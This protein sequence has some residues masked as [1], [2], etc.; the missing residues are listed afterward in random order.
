MKNFKVLEDFII[1]LG[2]MAILVI[3]LFILKPVIGFFGLI[4]LLVSGY[5]LY[6]KSVELSKKQV[7]IIEN[8]NRNFESASSDMVFNMPFP[9]V[10]LNEDSEVLWYNQPF[11]KIVN[12]DSLVNKNIDKIIDDIDVK[13]VDDDRESTRTIDLD[14]TYYRVYKNNV[15]KNN[16]DTISILYFVDDTDYIDV[17]NICNDMRICFGSV[18]IDNYDEIGAGKKGYHKSVITSEV[19]NIIL[20]YFTQMGG[21]VRKYDDEKYLVIANSVSLISMIEDK[22]SLLDRVRDIGTENESTISLSIGMSDAIDDITL[23][24]EQSREAV[25]LALG[26]GGDQVALRVK[27]GYEF[28]GGKTQAK[29]KRNR[30]RARVIGNSLSN[31]ID[32]SNRIFIMGHKNADLD[33]IGADIG[34]LGVVMRKNKEGYIVLNSSNPGIKV[35]L[36]EMEKTAG[37]FYDKIIDSE[38]ALSLADKT[39]SLVISVD[40]HKTVISE[41]PRLLDIVDDVVI[42]DHHRKGEDAIKDP[43]LSYVEPYA[44]STCEL[45][46]EILEF[47]DDNLDLSEFEACAMLAG[48]VLDTKNFTSKTGVRTFEAASILRR[49]GADP[50]KVNHYFNNDIDTVRLTTKVI[51]NANILDDK[52]AISKLEEDVDSG[53]LIAAQAADSLLN[54]RGIDASFVLTDMGDY[55]HVSGRSNGNVSVQIILEKLGGG[56]HLTSAA[57]QIRDHSIDESYDMLVSAIRDYYED[58][59]I[60]EEEN[61]DY[62][63][64]GS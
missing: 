49:Q 5:F 45:I 64:Q 14:G 40:N 46:T 15:E 52:I 32:E 12:D 4:I 2:L 55:I 56:G 57:C 53:I 36:E 27:D 8:L 33:A 19:E 47:M 30:V 11:L 1:P 41:E 44:S 54:I 3:I 23:A 10:L 29:E 31:L 37:D 42:I 21:V 18:Y 25:D 24:Y 59:K 43:V 60:Q 62:F 20:E 50:A 34:M 48:I 61:E 6:E 26:R 7:E 17:K 28:F 22:F 58:L 13:F 51:H 39:T 38:E 35:I 63:T 16:G 9:V